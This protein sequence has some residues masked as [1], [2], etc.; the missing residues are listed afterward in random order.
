MDRERFEKAMTLNS[1]IESLKYMILRYEDLLKCLEEGSLEVKIGNTNIEF[2]DKSL[3]EE[4]SVPVQRILEER[5]KELEGKV[6]LLGER[7]QKL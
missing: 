7:F 5:K 3:R 4:L 1:E 2:V 6:I